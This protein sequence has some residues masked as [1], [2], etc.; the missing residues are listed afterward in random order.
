MFILMLPCGWGS[1]T[2]VDRIK[3][4]ERP[5]TITLRRVPSPAGRPSSSGGGGGGNS[6]SSSIVASTCNETETATSSTPT[7]AVRGDRKENDDIVAQGVETPSDGGVQAEQELSAMLS[8]ASAN[9]PE[10]VAA[11]FRV[12]SE[13]VERGQ[14]S[15]DHHRRLHSAEKQA[16][17]AGDSDVTD[18]R[19]KELRTLRSENRALQM[20]LRDQAVENAA[21]RAQLQQEARPSSTS[22]DSEMMPAWD[23]TETLVWF[24]STFPFS[25]L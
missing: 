25:D 6:S 20:R 3:Y 12:C 22:S 13:Y 1:T 23:A 7:D 24:G 8:A 17:A 9:G 15:L 11:L 18:E 19:D 10:F 5:L 21:L 4:A 14:L 16:R 2:Q